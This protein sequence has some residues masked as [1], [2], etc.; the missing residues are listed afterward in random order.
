MI[1]M[2][3]GR[4]LI[5]IEKSNDQLNLYEKN[6]PKIPIRN[7][8]PKNWLS[9]IKDWKH[10]KKSSARNRFQSIQKNHQIHFKKSQ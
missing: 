2:G 3:H 8:K 4:T 7:T 1:S 10:L 5:N 6:H 9:N